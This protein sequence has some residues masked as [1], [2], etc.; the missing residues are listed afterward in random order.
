M[1]SLAAARWITST[2]ALNTGRAAPEIRGSSSDPTGLLA[3]PTGHRGTAPWADNQVETTGDIVENSE[4]NGGSISLAIF[5][6]PGAVIRKTAAA[7]HQAGRRQASKPWTKFPTRPIHPGTSVSGCHRQ[8]DRRTG[9]GTGCSFR[10]TPALNERC[11]SPPP[12]RLPFRRTER[13][14]VLPSGNGLPSPGRSRKDGSSRPTAPAT[15]EPQ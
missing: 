12:F 9:A 2:A 15:T 11:H 6:A 13:N 7:L 8:Q 5:H 10:T 14:S 1:Q 3:P 4:A